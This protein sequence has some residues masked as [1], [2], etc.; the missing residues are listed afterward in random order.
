MYRPKSTWTRGKVT[1]LLDYPR[2]MTAC[3][4]PAERRAIKRKRRKRVLRPKLY[5]LVKDKRPRP[6][7]C[8]SCLAETV[9]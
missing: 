5:K 1:H 9:S 7:T 8:M 3:G 2:D 4:L 6:V